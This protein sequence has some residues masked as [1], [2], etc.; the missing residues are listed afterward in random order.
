MSALKFQSY[1][2]NIQMKIISDIPYKKNSNDN[3]TWK[4]DMIMMKVDIF[5]WKSILLIFIDI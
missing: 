3:A 1:V 2:E 4:V 5:R